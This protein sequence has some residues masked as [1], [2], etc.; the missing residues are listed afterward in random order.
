MDNPACSTN[1]ENLAKQKTKIIKNSNFT[2][3]SLISY[4]YS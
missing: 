3:F 4:S 1:F 2:V